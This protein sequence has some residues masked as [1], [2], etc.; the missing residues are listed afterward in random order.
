MKIRFLLVF[1]IILLTVSMLQAQTTLK[2]A[3]VNVQELVQ[4]HPLLDSIQGVLDQEAKDMEQIYADML[5]EQQTKMDVFE[6]ES[7]G[8]SELMKKTKQ[9]ELLA[10]AQKIQNYNQ[11]AQQTLR[12]R[13]MELIQPVYQNVSAAINEVG[14]A[15]KI[16][17]VLDVSTGAVAYMAP[18]AQDITELVRQK[19][20][21]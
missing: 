19:F 3:H 12:Q 7:A 10:L 9:E 6:K 11:T 20:Q 18:D 13:N 1:P 8:Y 15:N 21:K 14:K 16:T 17:Y 4:T 5:E 2:V